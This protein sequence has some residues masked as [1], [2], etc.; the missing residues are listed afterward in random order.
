MDVEEDDKAGSDDEIERVAGSS[1][2]QIL[3]AQPAD[4]TKVAEWFVERSRFI[5]LRLLHGG[6]LNHLHDLTPA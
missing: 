2:L 3:G 4:G 5:P 1:S 6:S